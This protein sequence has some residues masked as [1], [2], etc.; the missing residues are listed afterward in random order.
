MTDQTLLPEGLPPLTQ[1]YFYLTAGCNLACQ[2]CWISPA[3]QAKGGTGGHL[4]YELFKIA[5]EEGIPLGLQSVKLTGGEPLLHPDFL[6]MVDL[7][8]EK[9][10]GLT[11]ETNGT[12]LTPEI[13]SHLRE[14]STL[15]HISVSI[16]GASSKSHDSFRGVP[17]SFEKAMAGV[18]MLSDVGFRPQIIMSLHP[19]NTDDIEE[20]VIL[21]QGWGAGSVKFN[22][23]QPTGRGEIMA[24][25]GQ[26]LD[27]THL[28]NLGT[29]V[30]HD[31][32]KRVSIDLFYSWPMIFHSLQR[33]LKHGS[34]SC[35]IFNIL[36]ILANGS[37]AMCGIG[38]EIPELTYGMLGRDRVLV[39]WRDNTILNQ[40]RK[41]L[42]VR[43]EDPCGKCL[44]KWQCLGSC[45]AENYHQA[46][47]LTAAYWFCQQAQ[48]MGVLPVQRTKA[49]IS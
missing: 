43:L 2:H 8:K 13:A 15:G 35:G 23:I 39:V 47:R 34:D 24:E 16:D 3:Y 32:Q 33:L 6:R 18:R 25:R 29:W 19:G 26:V 46:R 44:F 21:A 28:V 20:L 17:G 36:G 27:I 42:P 31:L 9:N 38:M 10:L 7:L 49:Q 45:V 22:L 30:E 11:I 1:Y 41:E 4:D 48:E 14:T 12:L 40:I 5:L 37:L